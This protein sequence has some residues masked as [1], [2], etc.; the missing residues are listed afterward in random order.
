M[1]QH[2]SVTG[3]RPFAPASRARF[4]TSLSSGINANTVCGTECSWTDPRLKSLLVCVLL[5]ILVVLRVRTSVG[6][7]EKRRDNV[8]SKQQ[9]QENKT[10]KTYLGIT[11]AQI[12][13]PVH[14][15]LSILLRPNTLLHNPTQAYTAPIRQPSKSQIQNT[16]TR[17]QNEAIEIFKKV[18]ICL[19]QTSHQNTKHN[20][21]QTEKNSRLSQPHTLL[22]N[23][24]SLHTPLRRAIRDHRKCDPFLF[25]YRLDP[26]VQLYSGSFLVSRFGWFGC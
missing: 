12:V 13:D 8:E 5:T 24:H 11:S 7:E 4:T 1:Q 14:K 15:E 6:G 22:P 2:M 23:K 25:A 21:N 18:S 3:R 16:N 26:S 20:K 10:E 19:T 9:L 17:P